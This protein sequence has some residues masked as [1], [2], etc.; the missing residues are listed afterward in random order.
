MVAEEKS[1]KLFQLMFERHSSVMLLIEPPSGRIVQANQAA[2]EF[3]GYT[4]NEFEKLTIQ[5]INQLPPK[6]VQRRRQEA[7]ERTCSVFIFPHQLKSGE[8]RTVEVH[9]TPIEYQGREL[10]F[11]V[12][13][14]ITDRIKAEQKL[15]EN[16]KLLTEIAANMPN[17]YLSII[18]QD[19]TIGFTSGSEFS[20]HNLDPK[21]FENMH[22]DEVFLK[23]APFVKENFKK[24]F[25]GEETSFEL[26]INDQYQLY[27]TTPLKDEKGQIN[28]IL[29]VAQN[30]TEQRE[31]ESERTLLKENL[32]QAQK[33]E[34][35]GRLAGGVAHDFNNL[36]CAIIANISLANEEL[37]E[38]HPLYEV[39]KE[40]E[41]AA[42]RATDLTK[43]LLTFSRKDVSLPRVV[44][45]SKV[46]EKIHPM[47]ER[48][49]GEDIKL[50]T[51]PQDELGLVFVDVSQMEQIVLNLAINGRD[52][53]P[54]GGSLVIET[55]DVELDSEYCS[56]HAG[57]KPGPHVMLAVS[58]TG[59]GMT[60]EVCE[61]VFE[62][63]FTTKELGQGTGLGLSTVYGIVEQN[64]GRI[65]IYSEVGEGTSFKVY[66]PRN[67]G[68][69][70]QEQSVLPELRKGTETILYVEDEDVVRR[71]TSKILK[72]LGY[73]V[74]SATSGEEA[75]E[76]AE[77]FNGTIDLLF[78]DVIM[79]Q[80]NGRKLAE[81]VRSL[82]PEI[83][84]LFTSGYTY[85]VIEQH[86]VLELGY[87]FIAKPFNRNILADGIRK[88]L[89]HAE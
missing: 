46:I 4:K 53:M 64:G 27:R 82:L 33:M 45:L 19:Y 15:R 71:S 41:I 61:K 8:L 67:D 21:S 13:H 65:E 17:A 77:S 89:D 87:R 18:E 58:D 42:D 11:S 68:L 37:E 51:V 38:S 47:L 66:F 49:I 74:I 54:D 72:R 10:L 73:Q 6:E 14:D 20:K 52:A 26:F 28:R 86:G 25:A 22:V 56:V 40:V 16:E 43:Q 36:L 31:A 83:K 50:R 75:L 55:A 76:I 70:K 3:Y 57:T 62:P 44:S 81:R 63:F 29:S 80:M 32:H 5:E 78:T 88:V 85:N 24:S 59:Q 23:H 39:L 60:P 9:S 69:I 84:V 34:A 35:I 48:L 30:V 79:P 12:I 7:A 1:E 2:V